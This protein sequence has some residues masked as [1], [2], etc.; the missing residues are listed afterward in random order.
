MKN[1][2]KITKAWVFE[3]DDVGWD[4]GRDLRLQKKAS[5]SGLPRYH[6]LEDYEVLRDIGE[7]SGMTLNV[8]L[9]LAVECERLEVGYFAETCGGLG[10]AHRGRDYFI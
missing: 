8:A 9:C 2:V 7:A 4:N 6:A 5:R 10:G 3:Y 1:S